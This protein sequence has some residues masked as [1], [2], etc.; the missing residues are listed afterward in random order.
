MGITLILNYLILSLILFFLLNYIEENNNENSIN[1]IIISLI[2][3]IISSGIIKNS[4]FIFIILIF[5]FL[6]RL[7]YTNYVLEKD[8]FKEKSSYLKE[9]I[10]S[11]TLGYLLNAYFIDKVDSVFL[12]ASEFRIILWIFIIIFTYTFVKDNLNINFKKNVKKY[13]Q[14]YKEYDIINYAKLKNLYSDKIK[15]KNQELI[16]V[17]YSIM[18]YNNYQRP[19]ILRKL[20]NIKY[21]IDNEPR[22]LGIMQINSK[23]NITD[24]E[25]I[26]LGIK[27]IERIYLK[28]NKEKKLKLEDIVIIIL[29]NYYEDKEISKEVLKIY[30]RI[31]EFNKN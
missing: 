26:E 15:I 13:E 12:T 29:N 22:K 20:D 1:R 31:I 10:I 11:I 4:Q 14:Q 8:F 21:R 3:M 30:K 23:K 25:S 17:I 7:F 9:Y 18:I 5:E 16:P 19:K 27:K 24:E 6:I 2:Y 28:F